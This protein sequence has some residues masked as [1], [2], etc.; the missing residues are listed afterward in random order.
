MKKITQAIQKNKGFTLIETLVSIAL[1]TIVLV[2]VGGTVVS[3]IDINKR[4]QLVSSVVN[5]LNYSIDSMV[6]D[7]KTGYLYKCD[8]TGTMTVTG[9]KDSAEDDSG[10]CIDSITLISTIS[11]E[12]IVVKYRFVKAEGVNNGYIEKTIY[13]N[14]VPSIY[15]ITDKKNVSIDSVNLTIKSP[16]ALECKGEVCDYGQPSVFVV[17]KGLAGNQSVQ[18]SK[19]YVQTYIS[20]R[21]INITD[22]NDAN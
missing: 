16:D 3:V 5:N 10:K 4:N 19:F 7:I 1:F 15:S 18:A 2:I 14:A 8:Y 9:L 13:K 12:D 6:R 21:V 22:F 17:I 11:G 20:Q